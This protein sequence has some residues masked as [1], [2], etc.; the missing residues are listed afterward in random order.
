MAM[1]VPK[2]HQKAF[3]SCDNAEKLSSARYVH[4]TDAFIRLSLTDQCDMFNE[5]YNVRNILYGCDK[6]RYVTPA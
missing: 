5:K 6:R 3:P 2:L 4:L 1:G